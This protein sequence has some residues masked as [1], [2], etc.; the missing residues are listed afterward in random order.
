MKLNRWMGLAA[1]AGLAASVQF[2]SAADI[3]GKITFKGAPPAAQEAPLDKVCGDLLKVDKIKSATYIVGPAGEFAD[4]VV[5][6]KGAKG[7]AKTE[8]LLVD[9]KDCV[10]HPYVAVAQAGQPIHVRNSD[11]FMHNVHV[12][13]KVA[14]NKEDNKAQFPKTPD[15]KYSFQPEPFVTFKCDVHPWM[16]SYIYVTDSPYFAVSQKDG[17]YKITGVPAGKY[18]LVA[19]H[20]RAGK[21]EAEIEV[22][23]AGAKK[24][25]EIEKK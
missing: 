20:R 19:E 9:Q 24:D 17:T 18:T 14:P 23:D 21:S 11:A 4:V 13:P 12:M 16:F 2:V 1:F 22:T 25:F 3:T 15:L 5:Y 8:P 7:A 10:Y 6:L